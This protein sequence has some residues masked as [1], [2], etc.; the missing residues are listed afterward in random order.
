MIIEKMSGAAARTGNLRK[1]RKK[2]YIKNEEGGCFKV[3]NKI[4]QALNR[5]QSNR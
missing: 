2:E 5:N 4:K 1:E 3:N